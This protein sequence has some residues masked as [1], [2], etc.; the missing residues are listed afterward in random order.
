MPSPP[1]VGRR[2]RAAVPEGTDAAAEEL[3]AQRAIWDERGPDSYEFSMTW[4]IF[5]NSYGDYRIGVADGAAVSIVK[6]ATTRLTP[7][8][9]RATAAHDR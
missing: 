2:L 4:H 6:D 3:A 1:F 9:W 5:N 8:A 7:P